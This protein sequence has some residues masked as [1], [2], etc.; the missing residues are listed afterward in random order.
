MKETLRH[1]EAFNFYYSLGEKR[2][3]FKVAQEYNVCR[4]AVAKWSIALDWQQRI[5]L[6]DIENARKLQEKVDATI[7]ASKANYRREIRENLRIIRAA[8]STA[9]EKLRSGELKVKD[10]SDI[11]MMAN[12]YEKLVKLDLLLMGEATDR[13]DVT[14]ADLARKYRQMLEE[15]G[16]Y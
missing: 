8:L 3:I 5:E 6:R 12:A 15:G 9:V 13:T 14:F 10:P 1:Q 11:G 7:I 16:Q 4:T 2:N